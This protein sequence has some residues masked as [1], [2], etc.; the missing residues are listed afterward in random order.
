[1]GYRSPFARPAMAQPGK[2]PGTK[3]KLSFPASCDKLC[4]DSNV[5]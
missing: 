3:K 4:Y 5:V 1:M 2:F